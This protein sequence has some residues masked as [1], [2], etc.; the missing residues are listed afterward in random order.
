M[1]GVPYG[2]AQELIVKLGVDEGFPEVA[3]VAGPD[4]R[5]VHAQTEAAVVNEGGRT[6]AMSCDHSNCVVQ[7][8][9]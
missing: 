7:F 2:K 5:R 4:A 6:G 3:G 9:L 8:M 1:A